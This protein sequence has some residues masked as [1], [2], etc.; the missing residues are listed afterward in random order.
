MEAALQCSRLA[1]TCGGE[2]LS[3]QQNRVGV[4][5]P[6]LKPQSQKPNKRR[7][8]IEG[9]SAH[10]S[11]R[12]FIAWMMRILHIITGSNGGRPPCAPSE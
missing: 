11:E 4:R 6:V 12:L 5:N 9:D 2:L 7:P 1:G 8:I 3:E 10:S